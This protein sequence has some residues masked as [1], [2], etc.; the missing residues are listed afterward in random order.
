MLTLMM[1]L[2]GS[3]LG[4]EDD[5]DDESTLDADEKTHKNKTRQGG[6]VTYV[7][8]IRDKDT[9]MG[10]GFGYVGFVVST[11]A[12]SCFCL[13]LSLFLVAGCWFL[14]FCFLCLTQDIS[15]IERCLRS[16]AFCCASRLF[17]EKKKKIIILIYIYQFSSFLSFFFIFTRAPYH[18]RLLFQVKV[19]FVSYLLSSSLSISASLPASASALSP[20]LCRVLDGFPNGHIFAIV[21]GICHCAT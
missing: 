16:G 3:I 14:F 8:I 13:C 1:L 11:I 12:E 21:G 2:S 4:E 6:W 17:F 20:S 5:S 18:P 7:R 10:K 19:L 15:N 9:M